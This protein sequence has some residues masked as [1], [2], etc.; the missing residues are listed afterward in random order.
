MKSRPIPKI[1]TGLATSKF[2]IPHGQIPSA[3][4][5][6]LACKN[7]K[8]VGIH[9]HIGSQILD[10]VPFAKA[11]EVM[12]R[13]AKELSEI[14]VKLEFLDLG[15][16]LGDSV[17]PRHRPGSHRKTMHGPS[18]R[19]FWQGLKRQASLPNSG[20]SRAAF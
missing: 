1:A 16:G 6:A 7:V 3:Y 13:I 17:P 11:A 9:C 2:G 8:P 18:C 10:V 12:V 20:S 19:S 4:R 15:G 14:G 5:E